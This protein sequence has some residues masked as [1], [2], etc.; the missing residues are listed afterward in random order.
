V[1]GNGAKRAGAD[2]NSVSDGPEE[3]HH[4]PIVLIG[5]ADR[6]ATSLPGD[7]QRNDAI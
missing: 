1:I 5:T 6:P 2:D 3:T 4:K 7:T